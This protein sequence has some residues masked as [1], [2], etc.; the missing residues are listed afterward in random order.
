M[1]IMD[2]LTVTVLMQLLKHRGVVVEVDV[3]EVCLY[4]QT[5]MKIQNK[6]RYGNTWLVYGSSVI[7]PPSLGGFFFAGNSLFQ[8][9]N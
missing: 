1:K 7:C 6:T 8:E 2:M 5:T 3:A 4:T 9:Q